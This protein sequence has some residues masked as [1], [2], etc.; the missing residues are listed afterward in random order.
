MPLFLEKSEE[1]KQQ[2]PDARLVYTT[3]RGFHF[4]MTCFDPL[5]IIKLP[6]H[7]IQ[8]VRHQASISFTTQSFIRYNGIF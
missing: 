1:E 4:S 3:H 2:L 5:S 6:S 7:F 8:I